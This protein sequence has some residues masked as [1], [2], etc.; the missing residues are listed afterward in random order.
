MID[1]LKI[2]KWKTPVIDT[3]ITVG[4]FIVSTGV[5][6]SFNYFG[7]ED[8]NF[9][10]IYILGILF[11]AVFTNGTVYS[12]VL[13]VFS[14]IGY[15]F[16]FTEPYFKLYFIDRMYIFTFIIMFVVGMTTSLITSELKHKMIQINELN[17]EKERLKSNAEK[18]K[19]KATLLRS[20]S[21]DLRTMLT[22][23]KNGAELLI[24]NADISKDDKNEILGDMVS[25]SMWMIRLVENLLS[26]SRIDIEKLTVKK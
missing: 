9:L 21:H 5:C 23:I 17:I 2:K 7:I 20:I 25:K 3:L 19:L 18:E 11:T 14:V 26:I 1:L 8:L 10:I 22:T 24:E 4:A 6:F 13:S 15:N 12:S 16:F